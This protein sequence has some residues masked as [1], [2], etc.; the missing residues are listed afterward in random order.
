[1]W[2]CAG[3]D[4]MVDRSGLS[5]ALVGYAYGEFHQPG[6]EPQPRRQAM[7]KN[8]M[9]VGLDVHKDSI[10]ITTAEAGRDREVRRFGQI[11]GDLESLDKAVRKLQAPGRKLH[12]VY[13]AGPCGYTIYRHLTKK[14]FDCKVVAP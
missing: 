11:A 14:G 1:M 12:F 3:L 9:H 10:E 5:L 6:T 13:E 7:K 2:R 4:I 8:N